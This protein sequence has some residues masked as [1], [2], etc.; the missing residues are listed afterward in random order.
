MW[1]NRAILAGKNRCSEGSY[2]PFPP[3]KRLWGGSI[4]PT[5]I[6]N[7]KNDRSHP[8]GTIVFVILSSIFLFYLNDRLYNQD[9][10]DTN[11][12]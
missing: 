7:D 9:D 12:Q 1:Q 4:P 5:R 8:A 10:L 6:P 3:D 11:Y 2:K